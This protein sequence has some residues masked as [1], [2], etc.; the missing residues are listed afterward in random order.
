MPALQVR[1]FPEELYEPLKALA[2][3]EHRSVSAQM[4][5]AVEQMLD[6]QSPSTGFPAIERKRKL[7]SADIAMGRLIDTPEERTKRMAKRRALFAEAEE[8]GKNNPELL[9]ALPKILEEAK[10]ERDA[11]G[12]EFIYGR[13]GD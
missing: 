2:K 11:R 1:D 4:V 12:D 10:Q 13:D 8:F 3:K 5:V 9:A 7:T 6:R